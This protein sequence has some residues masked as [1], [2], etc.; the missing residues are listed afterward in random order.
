LLTTGGL[1][2]RH[3]LLNPGQQNGGGLTKQ[4]PASVASIF[5]PSTTLV[6]PFAAPRTSGGSSILWFPSPNAPWHRRFYVLLGAPESEP[7]SLTV[8]NVIGEVGRMTLKSGIRVWVIADVIE[9]TD[10]MLRGVETA[11]AHLIGMSP[12]GG[13]GWA[14]GEVEGSPNLLD[15]ASVLPGPGE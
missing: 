3:G 12:D 4:R 15:V 11:R 1:P 13:A 8:N 7:G 2:R 6:A 5:T 9:M 10:E 14:W